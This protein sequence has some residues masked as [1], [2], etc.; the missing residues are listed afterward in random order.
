MVKVAGDNDDL[1]N[2]DEYETLTELQKEYDSKDSIE[3]NIQRPQFAKLL[4]KMFRNRLP[5]KVLKEK[6]ELQARPEN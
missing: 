4:E 6:L 5:D 1:G 3:K 2:G